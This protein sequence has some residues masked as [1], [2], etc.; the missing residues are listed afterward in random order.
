MSN[1]KV[2]LVTGANKG[3]GF[4]IVRQLA[5]RSY[6]VILTSRDEA[7]GMD[8]LAQLKKQIELQVIQSYYDLEATEQSY[9]AAQS[10]IKNAE[11]SFTIIRTKY[12][13]GQ[14]L[15]IEFLD[16]QN[17]FTTA[18]LAETIGAYEML[19]SEA[20]LQKTIANL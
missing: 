9:R 6:S 5:A 8:A 7:K 14:A 12:N 20:A 13:E 19:R 18:Q 17:K 3:I 1:K 10:G 2:I 16:A 11:K 15:L 4:E